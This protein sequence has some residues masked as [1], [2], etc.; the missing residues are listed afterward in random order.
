[1]DEIVSAMKKWKWDFIFSCMKD[2]ETEMNSPTWRFLKSEV[3][4]RA[5]VEGSN[6]DMTFVDEVGYDFLFRDDQRIEYKSQKK[7]FNMNGDTAKL[8]LKNTQNDA[9]ELTRTFDFLLIIQTEEPYRASLVSFD[10]TAVNTEI[11]RD[12]IKIQIPKESLRN[13][14]PDSGFKLRKQLRQF[15]GLKRRKNGLRR[16]VD[17]LIDSW[18]DN[19]FSYHVL[20]RRQSVVLVLLLLFFAIDSLF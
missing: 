6:G 12:G 17:V 1:M 11:V 20:G 7:A 16:E 2:I 10:D 14:T 19:S 3:L 13:I 5:I 15:F 4:S 18:V 8:K 9:Q